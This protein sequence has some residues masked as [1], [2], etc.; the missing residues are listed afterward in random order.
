[1]SAAWEGG[2]TEVYT[3]RLDF[4]ESRP[5]GFGAARLMAM[6]QPGESAIL[7]RPRRVSPGAAEGTLALVP[8]T[9]GT[10]KELAEGVVEADHTSVKDAWALALR[11]DDRFRVEFPK[12]HPVF[13][14]TGYVSHLRISPDG[15]SVA[16][17][18]HP[19]PGDDRGSVTVVGA[20][21]RVR[22]LGHEWSSAQG[23]AWS[24]DG[25]EVWFTASEAGPGYGLHAVDLGGAERTVLRIPGGLQLFDIHPDGRALL[26]RVIRRV[27]ALGQFPGDAAERDLSWLDATE[28]SD[29]SADGKQLLFFE[30]GEAG[31]PSYTTGLRRV[32]GGTPIRLGPGSAAALSPDG[33]WAISLVFGA[34]SKLMLL[35]TGAGE[36]RE[37]P[38]GGIAHQS[39]ADWLP[40]GRH[41]VLT[42]SEGGK[43][44]RLWVQDL[45]GS[46][47]QPISPEGVTFDYGAHPVSPDGQ[48]A[49]AIDGT[50][51]GLLFPIHGGEP[52]PLPGLGPG[53]Q[54]ARWA[55]DGKS[56]FVYRL[57]APP[58]H[59]DRYELAT[60][61][62]RPF[63][64]VK[65]VDPAGV[66]LMA[67]IQV[68]P[69]GRA[70]AY[71]L[72][73]MLTDLYLV[74]GL[75]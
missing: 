6:G 26:G 27:Y 11:R 1:Y 47:P 36:P 5:L 53:D 24:A 31:G 39:G 67:T 63:R 60:H 30:W 35:P 15:A 29:L 21:G 34:T 75:K 10:P 16:F 59:L 33:K 37:L 73:R 50:G 32:D 7:L 20:D 19:V 17:L 25:R 62:R 14:T 58:L 61:T 44:A 68:T 52:Q 28:T 43:G 55:S 13:E 22:V 49:A 64:E 56:F 66:A 65:P 2:D 42:G 71:T 69:D 72:S 9:G 57:G 70:L 3:T 48:W 45:D 12:G 51:K 38:S 40:D 41:I 74:E 54:I 23:L 18:H 4:L 46:K 8:L